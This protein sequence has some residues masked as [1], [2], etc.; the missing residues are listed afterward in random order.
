MSSISNEKL[1]KLI[2]DLSDK[3]NKLNDKVHN[4]SD[5]NNFKFNK[6]K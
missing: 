3:I 6:G 5:N 4:I 2:Q 1:Y